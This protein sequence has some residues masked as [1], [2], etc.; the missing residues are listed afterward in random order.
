VELSEAG[1]GFKH[2]LKTGEF[3]NRKH[4]ELVHLEWNI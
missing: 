1:G 4:M 2:I 3:I